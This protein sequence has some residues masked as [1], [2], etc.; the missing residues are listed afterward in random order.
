MKKLFTLSIISIL[1]LTLILSGCTPVANK[2]MEDE[3][4]AKNEAI[5]LL[6]QEKKALEE[7]IVK[8]ETE[9][10][11]VPMAENNT[12]LYT[13]LQIINLI[14]EKDMAELSNY[15][16][17]TKGLR[18]TAYGHIDDEDQVFNA[19]QLADSLNNSQTFT[20]GRYDGTGDPIDLSFGDYYDKFIY[21]EDFSSPHIIGINIIVGE[22]NTL[23][24]IEEFYPN[25]EFIEFHFKGFD[26]QYEGMDWKSLR[27]VF[28]EENGNL[29]LVGI[30]HDQWTI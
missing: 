15:I 10:N 14:K 30:I 3:I 27:L 26:P 4:E 16:H 2:E 13:A 11:E 20:W 6:E 17:P 8:L 29:Y 21:D 5:R 7:K 1:S 28:E 24:N 23:N 18:F 19:N 25:A 12:V 9:Q 22:G